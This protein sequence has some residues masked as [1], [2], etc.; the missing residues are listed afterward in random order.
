MVVRIHPVT[1]EHVPQMAAAVAHRVATLR[2]DVPAVPPAFSEPGHV[3]TALTRLVADGHGVVALT[4]TGT[5]LGHL[6]WR[7]FA[8]MRR[9]P[10]RA[11]YIPECGGA[12]APDAPAGTREDLFRAAAE[13]WDATGRQVIAVTELVGE[14]TADAFWLDNGFG[15]FLHDGVR[16]CTPIDAP[17]PAGFVIRP[18]NVD[19]VE[20]LVQLDVEHCA[21]YGLPPTF[22][23]PPVPATA[24]EL[25]ELLTRDTV[26]WVAADHDGP[27]AFLRAEQGADSCSEF[28]Q[29]DDTVGITGIFTRP[30]AR[31]RG[32]AAA[33]LDAALRHHAARGIPRFAFDYETIN[34]TARAFW[35][36]HLATVARSSMRVLERT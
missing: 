30:A 10:R 27:Q 20:R 3:A 5:V 4:P 16:P 8:S 31:G 2:R 15:R 36:R 35:P 23:V 22:M 13:Q 1:P 19:D 6:C 14:P 33:L 21:H 24:D 11:A 29:A 17:T 18:A 26:L 34:P 32:V 12:V 9:A 28:L 25:G 7:E